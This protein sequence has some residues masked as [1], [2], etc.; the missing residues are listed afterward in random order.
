MIDVRENV[1]LQAYNTLGL[2]CNAR[3]FVEITEPE[4][5][6]EVFNYAQKHQLETFVLSGGSNVILPSQ[7]DG[8]VISMGCLGIN[9]P[10]ETIEPVDDGQI[11]L[12][13]AAGENWHSLVEYCL[14]HNYYGIENLALIPGSVGAAPIQNIGAYGVELADIFHSLKGWNKQTNEWQTLTKKDCEFGYRDSIFKQSLKGLFVIT[15]VTLSLSRT[16]KVNVNYGV[17][18]NTLSE[19][20]NAN[21]TPQE[22]ADIVIA[23]RK[24]KLPDPAQLANVGS[25][26]KNPVISQPQLDRLKSD[27]P[28]II[29]YPQMDGKQKIAAGWLLER[30]GWKGHRSGD[31]GMHKDQALVMINYDKA[32]VDDVLGL[33]TAIQTDI[34]QRFSIALD[35]EPT[36]VS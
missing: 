16:A 25:F 18:S 8:L 22:I 4:C 26:F 20:G 35:I 1:E 9:E 6:P 32:N 34:Q 28:N 17:L 23:I 7:F 10:E 5:I 3:Y 15:S 13:V 2:A 24:S 14:A 21:P 33:A 36:L 30:A 11:Q 29:H 31:V 19:Q 27:Y 12:T